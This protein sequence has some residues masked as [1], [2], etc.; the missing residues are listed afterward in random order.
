MSEKN[1][2]FHYIVTWFIF[3]YYANAKLLI[4]LYP[5]IPSTARPFL[6]CHDFTAAYVLY[7]NTPSAVN[8][9]RN[10]IHVVNAG[11]V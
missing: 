5:A 1:I 2:L 11:V 6:D 10:W 7:Q 4:V 3:L 8:P 9:K